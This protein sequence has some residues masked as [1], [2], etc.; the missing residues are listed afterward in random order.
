M[1]SRVAH[2]AGGAGEGLAHPHALL[3]VNEEGVGLDQQVVLQPGLVQDQ[4]LEG[5]LGLPQAQLQ[6]LQCVVDGEDFVHQPGHGREKWVSPLE[7]M[8]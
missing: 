7:A 5:V 4:Q 1:S 2:Q 8:T 3:L 6:S